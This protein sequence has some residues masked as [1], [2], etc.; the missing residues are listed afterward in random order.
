MD[1]RMT[2]PDER[3]DLR[4]PRSWRNPQDSVLLGRNLTREQVLERR[5]VSGDLVYHAGT[6]R[7]VTDSWWLFPWEATHPASY[8]RDAIVAGRG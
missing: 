4:F 7:I 2:V 6:L 3:Y 1:T 5:T 8:A